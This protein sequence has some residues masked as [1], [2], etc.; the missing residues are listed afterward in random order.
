MVAGQATL[1]SL[2][3]LIENYANDCYPRNAALPSSIIHSKASGQANTLTFSHSKKFQ[4]IFTKQR[5]IIML[6]SCFNTRIQGEGV[7]K[8][9]VSTLGERGVGRKG[10]GNETQIMCDN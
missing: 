4:N 5:L 10:E 9:Y 6:C 1:A 7:F 3:Y 2:H 8:Y